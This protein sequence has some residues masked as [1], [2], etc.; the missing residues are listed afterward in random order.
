MQ[1]LI[2]TLISELTMVL[3]RIS[4][5]QINF[6]NTYNIHPRFVVEIEQLH[7]LV[8]HKLVGLH[9]FIVQNSKHGL[10]P[11]FKSFFSFILCHHAIV[12]GIQPQL[13]DFI[14]GVT[15]VWNILLH[16]MHSYA[17]EQSRHLIIHVF[18]QFCTL[19]KSY[20]CV[21]IYIYI[22]FCIVVHIEVKE[23]SKSVVSF[24]V[25]INQGFFMFVQIPYIPFICS[26]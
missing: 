14:C 21:C 26:W 8:L 4:Y 12:I 18:A 2:K 19:L 15:I 10:Y 13:Y 7:S 9:N 16:V 25:H 23:E 1:N 11:K 17:H 3:Y 5:Y 24:S 20:V 6:C 22:C